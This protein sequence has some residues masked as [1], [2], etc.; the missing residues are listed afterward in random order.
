MTGEKD[1]YT[2][3]EKLWKLDDEQLATPKHDEMTISLLNLEYISKLLNDEISEV[4]SEVPI[5][6]GNHFIVGYWDI[7][8]RGNCHYYNIEVK[9]TINSFGKVLRQ[10]KTYRFYQSYTEPILY[11]TDTKFDKEFE[12][13]GIIVIHP[14]IP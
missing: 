2:T 4:F 6:S 5:S 13:Q 14:I 10:L 8:A 7:V 12:S 1:R 11:T 9:P 3:Q